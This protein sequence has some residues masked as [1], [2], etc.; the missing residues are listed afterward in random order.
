MSCQTFL[1]CPK[2][3][4]PPPKTT[5]GAYLS[6]KLNL[7][8]TSL[9]YVAWK[10]GWQRLPDDQ[11]KENI[12]AL[13]AQDARG[14]VMDGN[15]TSSLESFIPDNATDIICTLRRRSCFPLTLLV[16]Q[17]WIHRCGII[18]LASSGAHSGAFLV[19]RHRVPK[20]VR[21]HGLKFFRSRASSGTA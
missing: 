3:Y 12:S 10:P 17:G 9:D 5:L 1:E 19:S 14:W 18:C 11:F 4:F 21:R 20:G 7:P 6:E 15:Y 2:V 13:M 8:H 16:R